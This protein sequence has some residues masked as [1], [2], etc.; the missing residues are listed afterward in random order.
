MIER[1]TIAEVYC[2]MRIVKCGFLCYILSSRR[3]KDF[4]MVN[5]IA[6]V[7]RLTG[8]EITTQIAYTDTT[9][10]RLVEI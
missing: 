6:T 7:V 3:L 8:T 1:K 9:Y 4:R 2:D 10:M 5:R